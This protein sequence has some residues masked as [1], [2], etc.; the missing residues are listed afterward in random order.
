MEKHPVR[1]PEE[2]LHQY[3]GRTQDQQVTGPRGRTVVDY[4]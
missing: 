3:Q 1:I 2:E 4:N